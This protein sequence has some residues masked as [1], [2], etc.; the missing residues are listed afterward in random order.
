MMSIIIPII[1]VTVIG[2]VCGI[3]LVVASKFMSV[4]EDETFL[5]VRECL[6]GANCGACGYAGCD[7]YA[8]ALADG[9]ISETN[10]CVPGGADAAANV[11]SALGLEAGEVVRK[12]A[13]VACC[14]DCENVTSRHE[15]VGI[16]SCS[17]ANL[18]FA[19]EFSCTFSCL[20][21]GD[22][23]SVCPNNA[24][25]VH[26]GLARI[27]AKLC[28]GCG[29]CSKVCPNHLIHIVPDTVTTI[30]G[31]SNQDKGAVTRKACKVGCIGCKK[32]ERECPAGAIKVV[33]NLAVID[34]EKCTNCGHCKEVCTT[35]CIKETNFN[36][37][38][39]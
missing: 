2:I 6:P 4:P 30:V 16:K 22:C 28:V 37:F 34:Y 33:N 19:G 38:N 31:C 5:A 29:M 21:Y 25:N 17:A 10:L 7:G 35:G 32:C 14:G 15:Y 39:W 27:N 1:A 13:Y 11:A 24:I 20:G 12:V 3:M 23:M 26:D 18:L 36:S 8:H 9:E